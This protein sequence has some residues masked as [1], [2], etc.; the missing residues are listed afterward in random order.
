MIKA[1]D[2]LAIGVA[3]VDDLLYIASYPP[4]N[5]KISVRARERHGGGPACTAIAAVGMLQG[6]SAYC[7]RLGADELSAYIENQLLQRHVDTTYIVRDSQAAPYHSVIAV[8]LEGNRNV[9]YDASRFSPLAP[10]DLAD[11]LILSSKLILLD[12]VAGS[13][14]TEIAKKIHGLGVPILGD[15]EGRT[16]SARQLLAF[17]DHLIVPCEFALWASNSISPREACASLARTGRPATV[18]TAGSEGCYYT[19]GMEEDIRH[20][21]AFKVST[22]DTNG[23]GDTFHGAFALA[24][25][26]DF[27][28]DDAILFASAAAAIKASGRDGTK[29][30]WD[31]L[32]TLEDI[33][34][35]LRSH[36]GIP[37]QSRLLNRIAGITA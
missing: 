32:P 21:P 4:P 5:V 24:T 33:V 19:K 22:H 36:P 10:E 3:A 7:A 23:C 16:S 11:S 13:A 18:V 37:N 30:G 9:F 12:H 1:Y 31:A 34:S 14:L 2:V 26:R 27:L 6:R 35:L 15:I 28:L 8:D 17:I 25:A 29:R 20:L